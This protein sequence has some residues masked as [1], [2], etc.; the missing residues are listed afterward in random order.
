MRE[1]RGAVAL[2]TMV[3]LG[4]VLVG[5]TGVSAGTATDVVSDDVLVAHAEPEQSAPHDECVERGGKNCRPNW[6]QPV[7]RVGEPP[8]I[9]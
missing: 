8:W 2:L 1:T 4:G 6:F 3:L 9:L 7:D 5:L